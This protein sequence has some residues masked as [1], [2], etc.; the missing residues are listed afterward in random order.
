MKKLEKIS[1]IIALGHEFAANIVGAAAKLLDE[2]SRK[3]ENI[4]IQEMD[5]EEC[6]VFM[7]AYI[8]RLSSA[9]IMQINA[10]LAKINHHKHDLH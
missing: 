7:R 2:F 5:D 6:V 4:I 10:I 3:P 8:E 9:Y 1:H